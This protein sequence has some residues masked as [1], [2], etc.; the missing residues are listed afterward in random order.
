MKTLPGHLRAARGA[1]V[2]SGQE[3]QRRRLCSVRPGSCLM[4]IWSATQRPTGFQTG[5]DYGLTLIIKGSHLLYLP[6]NRWGKR[7]GREATAGL[8]KERSEIC[9]AWKGQCRW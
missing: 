1:E 6:A 7:K 2:R 5:R 9:I 4:F 8:W 3:V